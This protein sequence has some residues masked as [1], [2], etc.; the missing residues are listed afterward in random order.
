MVGQAAYTSLQPPLLI[1]AHS[2]ARFE[3]LV[4]LVT[5]GMGLG[6][7]HK[8]NDIIPKSVDKAM[9]KANPPVANGAPGI[10]IRNGPM[11]EMEIDGPEV[12]GK[13]SSKRKS[14][15]NMGKGNSYKKAS[16]ED[17]ED[18]EPLVRSERISNVK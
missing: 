7:G 5:D 11:D 2:F 1:L 15:G 10:S 4:S 16:D 6:S 13:A 18:E 9:D 14:R 12:N 8:S 3:L 17:D